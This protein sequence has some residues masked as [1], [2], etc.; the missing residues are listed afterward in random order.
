TRSPSLQNQPQADEQVNKLAKELWAEADGEKV[1]YRQYG[2][3]YIMNGLSLEEAFE[4]ISCIPDC[5]LPEDHSI[6]YGHRT[7]PGIDIY[8][9]HRSMPVMDGM[10]F[11]KFAIGNAG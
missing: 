7:M 3:G 10:I 2:K 4:I 8:P 6:H 11:G 1:K 5:K 9:R